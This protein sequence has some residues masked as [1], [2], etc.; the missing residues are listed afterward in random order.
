VNE[1]VGPAWSEQVNEADWIAE[2]LSEGW[3]RTTSLVPSGYEAYARIL[4]PAAEPDMDL[5]RLVRWREVAA[6]SGMPMRKNAQFHSISL[7]PERP[8]TE[9]P[10]FG[11][12]PREGSLYAPDA[13]VVAEIGRGWTTTPDRCWFCV[14]DG[15]GWDN[16]LWLTERGAPEP[17]PISDPIPESVRQGPRVHLP[18]ERNHFL[19]SGP[20]E[21][22]V[23]T[24]PL[25]RPAQS[26]NLW[27]PQDRAWCVTT[28]L[29]LQWT[30]VAGP[31]EMIEQLLGDD[32]IEVLPVGPDDP[33]TRIEE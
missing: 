27:W 33:T 31:S 2:R 11:Q 21:A 25:S 12:G 30:Y 5:G 10:D 32:R 28:E 23:A 16:A 18:L 24:Y 26:P 3:A 9:P 7:P 22:V 19:Y 13:L 20:V 1:M 4:H 17:A 29:D 6:W 8:A 15:Y 14:W